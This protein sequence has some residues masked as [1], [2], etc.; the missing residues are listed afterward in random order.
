[1]LLTHTYENNKVRPDLAWQGSL[2]FLKGRD[3]REIV[4]LEIHCDYTSEVNPR[5]GLQIIEI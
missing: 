3:Y 4:G 1:M 5:S 2:R